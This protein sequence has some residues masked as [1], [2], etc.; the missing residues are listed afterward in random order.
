MAEGG[1]FA[2]AF[3]RAAAAGAGG[4]AGAVLAP[5]RPRAEGGAR[6]EGALKRR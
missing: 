4:G 5:R 2:R 6:G 3:A 1:G